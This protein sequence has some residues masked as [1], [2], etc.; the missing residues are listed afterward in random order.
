MTIKRKY[1]LSLIILILTHFNSNGQD[2]SDCKYLKG[3]Y[4]LKSNI[5]VNQKIIKFFP[6]KISQ[7]EKIVEFNLSNRVAYIDYGEFENVLDVELVAEL[8][9]GKIFL[10]KYFFKP[11]NSDYL[12]KLIVPNHS[13]LFLYFS[14]PIDRYLIA[15]LGFFEPS[16]FIQRKYGVAMQIL[17]KFNKE[18]FVEEVFYSGASYN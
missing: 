7:K 10:E 9:Y 5:E 14:K 18:G 11:Y 6:K 15:E 17:F 2:T 3:L 8:K 4:Y 12:E 13:S 1:Y 16:K